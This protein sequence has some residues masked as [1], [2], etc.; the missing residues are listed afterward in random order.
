MIRK[1][2]IKKTDFSIIILNN[3]N[4]FEF[5]NFEKYFEKKAKK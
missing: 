2:L 5:E 3:V 1:K 4:K